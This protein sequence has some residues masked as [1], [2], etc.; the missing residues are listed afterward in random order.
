MISSWNKNNTGSGILAQVKK[1]IKSVYLFI[2]P[3]LQPVKEP[4]VVQDGGSAHKPGMQPPALVILAL[5]PYVSQASISSSVKSGL[6]KI[7]V[8]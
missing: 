7:I 8:F 1:H 4:E 6:K 3:P 2:D 5:L